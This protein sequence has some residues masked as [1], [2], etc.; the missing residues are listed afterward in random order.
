MSQ[1]DASEFDLLPA[2][3]QQELEALARRYHGANGLG[4]QVLNMV[5]SQADNLL[6]RLPQAVRGQLD[7]A[8]SR[9]LVL[10]NDAAWRARLPMETG[11][12]GARSDW[13]NRL[14][15]TAM[16][17][18]GGFGG[19]PTALAELPIT[20]T[21]LLRAIQGIAE[22]SGFDT[23]D[24]KVRMQAIQ[25]F[26]A[27]GPMARNQ[28]HDTA[29]LSARLTLT[30]ATIHGLIA[31]VAPRLAT[32][33]GQKLAAQTVPVIGAMAGAATNYAFTGYYQ[34]MARVY[35]GL[36]ALSRDS[37]IGHDRLLK[38][39]DLLVHPPKVID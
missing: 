38:E 34:D 18:A 16:G 9:A 32:V 10:A 37:G 20:T 1:T 25:V 7:D 30:G 35:F 12:K 26:G 14:S 4:M 8:T 17:A 39:F 5:G 31:K 15:L 11:L 21:V 24:P 29:F 2:H 28:A 33:L 23:D 27:A 6:D 19:L 22:E 13:L 3:V 36:R